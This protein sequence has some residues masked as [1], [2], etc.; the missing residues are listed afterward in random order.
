MTYKEVNV[1]I[2]ISYSHKNKNERSECEKYLATI[3]R[4]QKTDVWYD[5]NILQGSDLDE[6]DENINKADIICLLLS[7]DYLDSKSCMEECKIAFQRTETNEIVVLPVILQACSWKDEEFKWPIALPKDGTPINKYG[8]PNE[9]W[10]EIYCGIKKNVEQYNEL[11]SKCKVQINDDFLNL[12]QNVELAPVIGNNIKLDDIFIPPDLLY[13]E[14]GFEERKNNFNDFL[15]SYNNECN[16]VF[17]SGD[18]QSGKTTL[19]YQLFIHLQNNFFP[20]LIDCNKDVKGKFE[21][22]IDKKIK[23]QYLGKISVLE[24]TKK[25]I[26]LLDDFH[27]LKTIERQKIIGEIQNRNNIKIIATVDDIYNLGIK[28]NIL[29][30]IFIHFSI[31]KIGRNLRDKL[32]CRWM[33]LKGHDYEKETIYRDELFDRVTMIMQKSIVPSYPFYIY[34]ILGAHSINNN[35]DSEITNQGH[36]YQALIFIA[37]KKIGI[38]NW[39]GSDLI[40]K[41]E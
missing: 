9:A 28:E 39:D 24:I 41:E 20:V 22:L 29:T 1:N 30:K 36:C 27:K 3:K 8:K 40:R 4:K 15:D 11:N 31:L 33:E 26:V 2:F 38:K 18:Q 7:Q 35:L 6:I 12:I 34:A 5:F 16:N 25:I 19:L 10:H 23:E 14:I 32:I 13:K 21:N 37:L 17:I